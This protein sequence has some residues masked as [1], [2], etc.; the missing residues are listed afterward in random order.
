MPSSPRPSPLSTISVIL[1]LTLSNFVA[2]RLGLL[3]AVPPGFATGVFPPAGI[4]MAAILL[5]GYR[6]WPG[7]FLGSFF[8]NQSFGVLVASSIATGSTLQAVGGAW[9][10]RRAI[11]FPASLTDERKIGKFL[12]LGGPIA[13]LTASTWGILTLWLSGNV[14][15]GLAFNWFAWWMGDATGVIIFGPLLFIAFGQPREVWRPRWLSVG[16]PLAMTFTVLAG[17][18]YYAQAKS[19]SDMRLEFNR[20]ALG[21]HSDIESKVETYLETLNSIAG[22]FNSSEQVDRRELRLFVERA[23]TR[24]PGITALGWIPRVQSHERLAYEQAAHKDALLETDPA[25]R[26]GLLAYRIKRWQSDARWLPYAAD[27][28]PGEMFPL[29]FLEPY[30]SNEPALGI[31]FGSQPMRR[32]TLKASRTYDQPIATGPIWLAQEE[33]RQSAIL[34][35]V[36]IHAKGQPRETLEQRRKYLEGFASGLVRIRDLVET[37]CSASDLAMID[38]TLQDEN[39]PETE[40]DRNLL[41]GKPI[42][43]RAGKSGRDRKQPEYVGHLRVGGRPWQITITPSDTFLATSRARQLW[44][45]LG[46]G[47]L[48]AIAISGSTLLVTGRSRQ[49]ELL[50]EQ[51]TEELR[52]EQK[53]LRKLIDIQ[54]QERQLVAHDIHD[55]FL[56]DIV[57]A[58]FQAQSI[59]TDTTH[60]ANENAAER[61]A[62]LLKKAIAEGRRLIRDLRPMVLDESGV[63]EAIEHFLAEDRGDDHLDV[64][65]VHELSTTRFDAGVEGVIFRI[66]QEA[67]TN[68]R[69]H[70]KTTHAAVQLAQENGC[71][72]LTIRDRGTGFDLNSVTRENFGLRGI[73]ER[74]RLFGGHADITSAVGEGTTIFVTIPVDKPA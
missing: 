21:V 74:A 45:E 5:F 52:S 32:A 13:C 46:I 25:I 10:I 61:V 28:N 27:D 60:S 59:N 57:G 20:L 17:L 7:V 58:Y 62:T 50:V 54:E 31:D 72:H 30:H 55:G 71:I 70:A 8:L 68:V 12:I 3:L 36:S 40:P 16:L 48:F 67:I 9:L 6:V 64:A 44:S 41:Y 35:V 4:A 15:Q 23:F 43:D 42:K 39:V 1:A 11:G 38:L 26:A 65:F 47:L 56:Q 22:L 24:Q 63:V 34:L 19:E 18:F 73:R 33:T 51:K 69:R 37:S 53:L 29:H 49:V 2:G 66:V 14:S